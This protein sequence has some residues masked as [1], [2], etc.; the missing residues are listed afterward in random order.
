MFQFLF[1]WHLYLLVFTPAKKVVNL[2]SRE[3][4]GDRL[5]TLRIHVAVSNYV[6][7]QIWRLNAQTVDKWV[8]VCTLYV[9]DCMREEY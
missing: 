3:I 2:N 8:C 9:C 5:V 6:K 4:S 7:I 1:A